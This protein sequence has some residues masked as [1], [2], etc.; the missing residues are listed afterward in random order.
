MRN[1][2]LINQ[3]GMLLLLRLIMFSKNIKSKNNGLEN[4]NSI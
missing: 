2:N 1:K 3:N 4:I